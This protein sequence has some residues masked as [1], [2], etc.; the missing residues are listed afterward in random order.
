M[1]PYVFAL[2]L[3]L[4]ATLLGLVVLLGIAAQLE[5][6]LDRSV[7]PAHLRTATQRVRVLPAQRH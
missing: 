4:P 7:R 2:M 1:N 6:Q 5:R 3:A